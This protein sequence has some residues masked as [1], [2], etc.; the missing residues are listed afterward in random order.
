M[1]IETSRGLENVV[2]MLQFTYIGHCRSTS[3]SHNVVSKMVNG[4]NLLEN[5]LEFQQ[6]VYV[7]VDIPELDDK[8]RTRGE[9]FDSA[10]NKI[11]TD[12]RPGKKLRDSGFRL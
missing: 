12:T 6:K 1:H 2:E 8:S 4:E 3:M 5:R 9:I 11:T 7:V 10:F